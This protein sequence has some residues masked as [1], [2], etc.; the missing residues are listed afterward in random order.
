MRERGARGDGL[1]SGR[2]NMFRREGATTSPLIMGADGAR[3]SWLV[4][5]AAVPAACIWIGAWHKRL[6]NFTT[7]RRR[8][9]CLPPPVSAN[10]S[11]LLRK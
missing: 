9:H 5:E 1:P 2:W 8:W 3:P 4:V 7:S 11:S 10:I 6:Y